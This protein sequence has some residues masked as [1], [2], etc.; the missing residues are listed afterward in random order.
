M[1]RYNGFPAETILRICGYLVHAAHVW[2]D[3]VRVN[4]HICTCNEPSIFCTC[5]LAELQQ[6]KSQRPFR[7]Q[8]CKISPLIQTNNKFENPNIH[9]RTILTKVG[10]LLM[11]VTCADLTKIIVP[12]TMDQYSEGIIQLNELSCKTLSGRQLHFDK[13]TQPFRHVI[14]YVYGD[15]PA[16]FLA[17]QEA[18]A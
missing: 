14:R 4:K 10:L 7:T 11:S 2:L 8:E 16:M 18:H 12:K 5:A 15:S 6:Y 1:D 17:L 13:V 9:D 3:R